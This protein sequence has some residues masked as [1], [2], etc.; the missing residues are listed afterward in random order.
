MHRK[1]QQ[2]VYLAIFVSAG[3][4]EVSLD[5]RNRRGYNLERSEIIPA[6]R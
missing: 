3:Q 6:V 2:G 1:E 5:Y 4:R